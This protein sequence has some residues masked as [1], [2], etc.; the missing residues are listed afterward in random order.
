MGELR[1]MSAAA[2]STIVQPPIYRTLC[3]IDAPNP[4]AI[5][6]LI[7][8]QRWKSAHPWIC[9]LALFSRYHGGTMR[10]CVRFEFISAE[11][12]MLIVHPLLGV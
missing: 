9:I 1:L 6:P 5:F 2:T 11:T 4:P 7:D 12:L 3:P 8:R 10:V